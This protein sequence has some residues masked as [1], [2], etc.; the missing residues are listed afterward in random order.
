MPFARH[1][2]SFWTR[3]SI[4][5]KRVLWALTAIAV[6]ILAGC[7]SP[8]ATHRMPFEAHVDRAGLDPLIDAPLRM[9][10]SCKGTTL[11]AAGNKLGG[12]SFECPDLDVIATLNELRDA[13]WR[14]EKMHI[15]K[16]VVNEEESGTP[17]TV[18]LRKVY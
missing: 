12:F 9:S 15:G 7:S 14:V 18:E 6:S 16:Q 8:P 17:L 4:M 11:F 10:T 3:N 2:E 5:L 13:G 1:T